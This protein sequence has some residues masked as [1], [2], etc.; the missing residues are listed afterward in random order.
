MNIRI[1]LAILT[2]ATTLLVGCGDQTAS[3]TQ[4]TVYDQE[5]I[6]VQTQIVGSQSDH[7]SSILSGTIQSKD[8]AIVSAR[9][10][11]YVTSLNVDIGD[12]VSKGQTILTIESN[13]LQAKKAQASAGI[14]EAEAALKNVKINYDRMKILWEQESITRKEWDDISTQYQVMQAKVEGAYQMQNEIDEMI[15]YTR[16]VAPLSGLVTSKTINSG[17]LVNPGI[18]LMTIEGNAGFEV[19]SHISDHQIASVNMGMMVDC[20]IKAI[21][22]TIKAKIT[23]ISPSAV[24]TSGQFAIKAALQLN[25]DERKMVFSGMYADVIADV[26][27]YNQKENSTT[28]EKSALIQRGQLTGVYTISNQNT[29]LL[30]WI[31]VGKDLGDRVEVVTGLTSGEEY[32]ASNISAIKDGIPVSK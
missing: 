28:I 2:A 14:A 18:P 22:K 7:T 19:V 12:R 16:V 13:E 30:R 29:A 4:N 17:D 31:R 20:Q 25:E 3:S 21:G 6:K 15:R 9:L 27:R 5:P 32:I 1:L 8:K 10:M 11:G 26:P 23:E 24:Y